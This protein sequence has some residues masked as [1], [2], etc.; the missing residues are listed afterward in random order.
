MEFK[1]E[2]GKPIILSKDVLKILNCS[3]DLYRKR[4]L[5]KLDIQREHIESQ[6]KITDKLIGLSVEQ[7]V[8]ERKLELSIISFREQVEFDIP[9]SA[10]WEYRLDKGME[11]I[12][13]TRNMVECLESPGL[14][15]EILLKDFFK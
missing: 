12:T 4:E 3:K 10:Y 5:I 15:L 2:K 8:T 6:R 9:E 1:L 11:T 14:K 7:L 13:P